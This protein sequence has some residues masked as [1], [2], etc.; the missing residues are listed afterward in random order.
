[1]KGKFYEFVPWES[2]MEWRVDPWGS[3]WVKA[4]SSSGH[5]VEVCASCDDAGTLLRAPSGSDGLVPCCRDSF[6]AKMN[7]KLW[8]TS[9][10]ARS[11]VVDAWSDTALT[12]VGGGPWWTQWSDRSEIQEP[13]KT[14]CRLPI[15]TSQLSKSVPSILKPPGL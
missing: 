2:E 13:M 10:G 3:W 14:L 7:L 15:D 4:S 1:M 6:S 8:K 11:L 9:T 12:E 5:E